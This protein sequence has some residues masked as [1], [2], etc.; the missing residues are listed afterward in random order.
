MSHS[1]RKAFEH[2]KNERMEGEKEKV[3]VFRS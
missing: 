1:V 2:V 3:N